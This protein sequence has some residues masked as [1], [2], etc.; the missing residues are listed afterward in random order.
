M[1]DKQ[2]LEKMHMNKIK[3]KWK[4]LRKRGLTPP[5]D[6]DENRRRAYEAHGY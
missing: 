1:K 3:R 5:K 4:S 2:L 6:S